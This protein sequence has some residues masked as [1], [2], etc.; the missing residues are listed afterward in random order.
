MAQSLGSG[1]IGLLAGLGGA[2][3]GYANQ[4]QTNVQN[5]AQQRKLDLE[6]GYLQQ[7]KVKQAS[8]LAQSGLKQN[9]DGSVTP[10]QSQLVDNPQKPGEQLPYLQGM[11]RLK[12]LANTPEE[13]L[14]PGAQIGHPELGFVKPEVAKS[15]QDY[16]MR[17]TALGLIPGLV[18]GA[19]G[20]QPQSDQ[21]Q[22][23]GP[24][25][26]AQSGG[27]I[28][29]LMSPQAQ[30]PPQQPSGGY[31]S[32]LSRLG[33]GGAV[34]LGMLGPTGEGVLK[35]LGEVDRAN[36]E[37]A[38]LRQEQE[39]QSRQASQFQ[40]SQT[41]ESN[42]FQQ[43]QSAESG[44]FST[45]AK[46]Q[47]IEDAQNKFMSDAKPYI[48]E[49]AGAQKALAMI[50]SGKA[51]N[52]AEL[53]AQINKSPRLATLIQNSEPAA[54]KADRYATSLSS[55]IPGHQPQM[56]P[57]SVAYYKELLGNNLGAS[58][59]T[60]NQLKAAHAGNLQA[61]N[62]SANLGLKQDEINSAIATPLDQTSKAPDRVKMTLPDGS[63]AMIPKA[64]VNAAVRRGAKLAQ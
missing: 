53:D 32:T 22:G 23:Q 11:A 61:L 36:L 41:R 25:Q 17:K 13:G 14:I 64:N 58:Q 46:K 43:G 19:T 56:S 60:I 59:H 6:Q 54:V 49:Q 45:T 35:S 37:A 1:V 33:A 44:R 26:A 38:R 27:M 8:E 4:L 20:Q 63:L 48:E 21:N 31:N 40:Q 47:V 50:N 5:A 7:S 30:Q 62:R 55:L 18:G 34:G 57:A 12:S 15:V 9:P 39:N 51:V 24:T 3:Q 28:S 16:D 10:D 52:F 42:Q 2:T 29:G